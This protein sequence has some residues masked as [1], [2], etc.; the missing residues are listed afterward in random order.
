MELSN[1]VAPMTSDRWSAPLISEIWLITASFLDPPGLA[2][3]CL[4]SKAFL[5]IARP[6]LYRSIK[7]NL[8]EGNT[9]YTLDLLSQNEA[10][11]RFVQTLELHSGVRIISG[12]FPTEEFPTKPNRLIEAIGKMT[13]L[14]TLRMRGSPFDGF[15]EER[16]FSERLRECNIPLRNFDFTAYSPDGTSNLLSPNGLKLRN[17]RSLIWGLRVDDSETIFFRNT[18]CK[19]ID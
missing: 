3:L 7:I 12:L 18:K 14:E 19:Y 17:L 16:A 13:S 1:L 6:D 10:L 5:E 2:V 8:E 4:I 11:A 9:D 15:D